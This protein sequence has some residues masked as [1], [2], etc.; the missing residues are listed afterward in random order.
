MKK[1]YR[2]YRNSSIS[3]KHFFKRVNDLYTYKV[4]LE[5]TSS[6]KLV[7]IYIEYI[8]IYASVEFP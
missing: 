3:F 2:N 1:D 4:W 5:K 7:Y 8:Y 6:G